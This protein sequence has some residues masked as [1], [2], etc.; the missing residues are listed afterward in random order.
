[1]CFIENTVLFY[2]N[3]RNLSHVILSFQVEVT[4]LDQN[5]TPPKF[6]QDVWE[7]D[8]PEDQ[9]PG[10]PIAMV[11]ATDEDKEGSI[12]YSIVGGA[13]GLFTID[14]DEGRNTVNLVF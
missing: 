4:V 12:V 3:K 7:L 9:S 1:M 6:D 13:D 8:V 2:L 10:E 5:D 14:S 11:T